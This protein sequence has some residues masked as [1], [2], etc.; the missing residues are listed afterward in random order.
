MTKLE[1]ANILVELYGKF[2]YEC[3]ARRQEPES[4]Y[5]EA[6]SIACMALKEED[7]RGDLT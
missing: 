2:T 3:F 1:A 6:I 5:S 4:K 7:T